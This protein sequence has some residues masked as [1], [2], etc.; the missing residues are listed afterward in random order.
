MAKD[1]YEILGVSRN[2]TQEEIKKAYRRLA[3]KYHPDLNPGDKKA[4]EK[5][6]EIQEAY[7]VLSDPKK[8]AQYDRF[9]HVG[10][11]ASHS[12]P[13]GETG[14]EGFDFS[15]LGDFSFSDIFSEIFGG[16][17]RTSAEKPTRGEDLTYSITIPFE[18]AVRGS[19]ITVKISR[20]DRCPR[21][22]G[23]G[24]EKGTGPT[25]CPNCGGTGRIYMQRGYLKFS[26]ICP[27]C[28][29]TGHLPGE[30]CRQCGGEGR[31][32]VEDTIKVK[33]PPGVKDGGRL[34]I[35]GKGNAG[36]HGGPPGDL[37]IIVNVLPHKYFKRE[38]DDIYLTLPV[39]YS[40]AAL[41]ATVEV[42]TIDGKARVKIPPGTP[43]GKKLRLRGKGVPRPNGT[44][45]DMYVEIKIVPPDLTDV[46]AR[47]LL[48][49]LSQYEGK[50]PREG[51]FK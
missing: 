38:G 26:S 7:E 33:I 30:K 42:P 45:G 1:Y 22:G 13:T 19:V 25:V 44:R 51:L 34:R 18:E 36:R 5:F 2:A 4:E 15:D 27:V 43:S 12:G 3:R 41:G 8:R 14:F 49:E 17:R 50:N 47:E 11:F 40:E 10:N 23:T 39:T 32:K 28:N 31:I 46:R 37:Y 24:Y 29:G 9:G 16:G 35:G 21:C 6:K 20:L 48:K